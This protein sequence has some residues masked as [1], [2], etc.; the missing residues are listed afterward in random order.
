M[1]FYGALYVSMDLQLA[2]N[3]LKLGLGDVMI[4]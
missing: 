1:G 2:L 4:G 3:N